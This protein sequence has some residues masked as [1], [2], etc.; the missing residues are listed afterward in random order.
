MILPRVHLNNNRNNRNKME[1]RCVLLVCN[2]CGR[3]DSNLC[4][5]HTS[6]ELQ[7]LLLSK[8]SKWH[9][10]SLDFWRSYLCS[11]H[12]SLRPWSHSITSLCQSIKPSCIF[13]FNSN[14]QY[15]CCY[16]CLHRHLNMSLL[17]YRF[18]NKRIDINNLWTNR[19]L[20]DPLSIQYSL[21]CD[22]KL[23]IQSLLHLFLL[24][25]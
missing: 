24:C 5:V 22:A 1:L 9:H 14:G 2:I 6:R 19:Y 11:L 16:V 23:V 18:L 4:V 17:S 25:F 10:H 12:L 8:W 3:V 21:Y 13:V 15:L 7:I 20:I